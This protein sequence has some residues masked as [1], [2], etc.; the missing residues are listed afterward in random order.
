MNRSFR[1]KDVR[2]ASWLWLKVGQSPDVE[3]TFPK[4][5]VFINSPELS[6][7][8]EDFYKGRAVANIFDLFEKYNA[9]KALVKSIISQEQEDGR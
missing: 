5:F 6:K 9:L 4:T 2:L 8:I 3:G 1:T 7:A